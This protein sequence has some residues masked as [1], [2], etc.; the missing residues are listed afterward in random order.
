MAFPENG[1]SDFPARLAKT[2]FRLKLEIKRIVNVIYAH[3]HAGSAN[4]REPESLL[5]PLTPKLIAILLTANSPSEVESG[6][7]A[8]VAAS[9][10][11]LPSVSGCIALS[12]SPCRYRPSP[13]AL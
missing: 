6:G 7:W 9:F 3:L 13:A 8:P 11:G 12:P 1:T 5:G 4:N 2:S 10:Q